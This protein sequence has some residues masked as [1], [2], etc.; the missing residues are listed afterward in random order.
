MLHGSRASSV[1]QNS[2]KIFLCDTTEMFCGPHLTNPLMWGR[3]DNVLNFFILFFC[4]VLVKNHM[5]C[6][7]A[8]VPYR[9][10]VET[11]VAENCFMLYKTTTHSRACSAAQVCWEPQGHRLCW[12]V[13]VYLICTMHILTAEQL[14]NY[15]APSGRSLID[16]K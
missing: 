11:F 7:C 8:A 14:Q 9:K 5:K 3:V 12:S 10:H 1:F 2:T 6:A 15:K 13:T 16:I 4:T